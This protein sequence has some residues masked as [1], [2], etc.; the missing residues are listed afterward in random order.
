MLMHAGDSGSKP[1]PDKIYGRSEKSGSKRIVAKHPM[2][3][4]GTVSMGKT[5][6][7]NTP[8]EARNRVVS[9]ATAWLANYLAEHDLDG[10]YQYVFIKSIKRDVTPK[11]TTR[12]K[13]YAH[14]QDVSRIALQTRAV[15]T[16]CLLTGSK[17]RDIK[18]LDASVQV[19]K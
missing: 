17:T 12:L 19:W 9:V 13:T 7:D 16:A 5:I 2:A 18:Y 6:G 10:D 1:P 4:F 3:G 8:N 11:T 15:S 14:L